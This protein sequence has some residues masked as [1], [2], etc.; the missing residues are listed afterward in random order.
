MGGITEE[1]KRTLKEKLNIVEIAESYFTLERNGG[2]YWACCPFHHEKTPSFAINEAGQFYHCFGCGVSGDVI[3]FVQEMESLDFMGAIKLLAQRVQLPLPE[4]TDDDKRS[5]ELKRKK[6]SILKILNDTAHFYFNNLSS[7]NAEAHVAYI[8]KREIP[9]SMVR[10]FGMGASLDFN[11]L[12]KFL[13]SKGYSKQDIID[14]GVVNENEGRLT[15]AQGGRLIFPIIN[16]YGEVIAFG[17]RVLNKSNTAKYVNT[18]DT[19]VFTKRKNLFN[20]NLVKKL[21]RSQTVKDIIMVEGYLDVVSLYSAGFKNVVA[22]MGTSL[23]QDQA[24]LIKRFAENVYISYDGDGAGQK[25]NLRGMD[26]LKD[27]GLNVKVVPLPEG[28]DPDDVIK[29]LGAEG[30][31]KCLDSAMPLIDYKLSVLS[32][33]FDITKTDEKRNYIAS[34]LEVVKTADS[35]TEREELLKQLRDKTGVSFEALKRDLQGVAQPKKEKSEQPLRKKDEVDAT[36]KASRF[37]ISAFLFGADFTKGHDVSEVDYT[38]DVHVIIS[39]YIKT[40][41]LMEEQ[42]R[43]SELFEFFEEN[44]PE[45]EELSRILDYSNG[46]GFTG[47]VAEKYFNDCLSKLKITAIEKEIEDAGKSLANAQDLKERA[48]IAQKIAQ[49]TRQKEKLKNGSKQ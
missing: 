5:I 20:I 13:L 23:T 12:P 2:N 42:I 30:Y 15:D 9:A 11:G 26:I 10:T 3:K 7:G 8:L 24:R 44:S 49:L 45:A 37:V 38:N 48:S 39:K 25:A 27:E 34:A 35:E 4:N 21:K 33:G 47:D 40:K 46:G 1:F 32:K 19:L 43:L 31:Q 14:S 36:G 28:M 17:G 29:K 22:S 16:S 41:E 18:R 6:D